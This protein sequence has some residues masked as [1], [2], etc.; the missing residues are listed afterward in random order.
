MAVL[1]G[2]IAFGAAPGR[3]AHAASHSAGS[4]V[5]LSLLAVVIGLGA[6]GVLA[7][8]LWACRPQAYR[9]DSYGL[10]HRHEGILMPAVMAISGLGLYALGIYLEISGSRPARKARAGVSV[11]TDRNPFKATVPP[12]PLDDRALLI[13]GAVISGLG[14]I[15]LLVFEI[16]RRQRHKAAGDDHFGPED[17]EGVSPSTERGDVDLAA[18]LATVEIASA[19]DEPDPRRA[20]VAAYLETEA[21]LDSLGLPRGQDET[22]YEYLARVRSHPAGTSG[23]R[24]GG[25]E[26]AL[27]ELTGLFA[28]ARYS[29]R[30]ITEEMR[31]AAIGAIDQI[32]EISRPELALGHRE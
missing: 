31:G 17:R 10:M 8:I 6:L 23:D 2:V 4:S 16:R 24:G 18:L 19:L 13:V 22:P 29:S 21:L 1:L 20:I 14:L 32:R 25:V 7:T 12:M 28:A 3:G 30:P 26:R 9:R 11:P 27:S 5:L 15:G